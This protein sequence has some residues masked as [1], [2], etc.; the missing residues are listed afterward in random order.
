MKLRVASTRKNRIIGQMMQQILAGIVNVREK[1]NNTFRLLYIYLYWKGVYLRL[2]K[3][4]TISALLTDT[5]FHL[6]SIDI[7]ESDQ[8][9]NT[10]SERFLSRIERT[11]SHL[12]RHLGRSIRP[13][14][15][16][17]ERK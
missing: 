17:S 3:R 15:I 14:Q 6:S 11:S 8:N 10:D 12:R 1:V 13:N 16:L 5:G 9:H 2:G 7:F 4:L